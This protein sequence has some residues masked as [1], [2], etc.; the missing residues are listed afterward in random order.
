MHGT[1][2]IFPCLMPIFCRPPLSTTT[3][4]SKSMDRYCFKDRF[5]SVALRYA[6]F[7]FLVWNTTDSPNLIY[8]QQASKDQLATR[9]PCRPRHDPYEGGVSPQL[10]PKPLVHLFSTELYHV[11]S[12]AG[13][14]GGVS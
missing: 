10:P 1:G 9:L 4:V 8:L 3:S 6:S 11:Y 13:T 12:K 2:R 5:C 14:S 7:S